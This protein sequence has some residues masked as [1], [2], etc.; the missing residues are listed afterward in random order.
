[1]EN[2]FF[3]F[4]KFSPLF[5][6][7]WAR[8]QSTCDANGHVIFN[9]GSS[10][11]GSPYFL[12]F[13]FRFQRA[14]ET[15]DSGTFFFHSSS[16]HLFVYLSRFIPFKLRPWPFTSNCLRRSS[17]IISPAHTVHKKLVL[18]IFNR[19]TRARRLNYKRPATSYIC[20]YVQFSDC[21]G[22]EVDSDEESVISG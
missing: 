6:P 18:I 4:F 12:S 1:M 2:I 7:T 20:T 5:Q 15:R 17:V 3:I 16:S 10:F 21:C 8:G 14:P 11:G 22:K 13:S 19:W 9:F